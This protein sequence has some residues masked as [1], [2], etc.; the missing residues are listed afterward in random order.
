MYKSSPKQYEP[1]FLRHERSSVRCLGGRGKQGWRIIAGRSGLA[2]LSHLATQP[3]PFPPRIPAATSS[4]C[5]TMSG[6]APPRA[7][8]ALLHSFQPSGSST[9]PGSSSNPRLG[10]TPP[11]GPRSLVSQQRPPPQGPKAFL[12][13]KNAHSTLPNGS[14]ASSSTAPAA[15]ANSRLPSSKG[16]QVQV[17]AGTQ[18]L[19]ASSSSNE[20]KCSCQGVRGSVS[21]L[22][23]SLVAIT[24]SERCRPF[25]WTA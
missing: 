15:E 12:S 19:T 14:S 24:P 20:V 10:A 7:P 16:K 22:S 6:K 21:S 17:S 1:I 2:A 23:F 4:S 5:S 25:L 3:P 13:S 11:T 18:E 8:R 9:Q